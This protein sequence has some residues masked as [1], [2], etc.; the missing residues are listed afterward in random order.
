MR[1]PV[2]KNPFQCAHIICDVL[3][4]LLPYVQYKKRE[5]QSWRSVTFSLQLY[6]YCLKRKLY[7]KKLPTKGE[8]YLITIFDLNQTSK[9]MFKENC[10][11]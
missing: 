10:S 7:K 9:I 11:I 2:Y 8:S 6:Y 1:L 5:K 3:R 4:D